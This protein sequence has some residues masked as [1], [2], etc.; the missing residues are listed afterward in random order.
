[1]SS[2][3]IL[4]GSPKT[5]FAQLISWDEFSSNRTPLGATQLK[6][7]NLTKHAL[8]SLDVYL[9]SPLVNLWTPLGWREGRGLIGVGCLIVGEIGGADVGVTV[10]MSSK[11]RRLKPPL[12][13][14]KEHL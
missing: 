10:N 8:E 5:N 1:M 13:F 2:R 3:T 14:L 12:C 11:M 6:A 9:Q 4:W 7:L